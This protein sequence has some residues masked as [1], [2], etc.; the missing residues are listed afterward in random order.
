MLEKF[1]DILGYSD[2]VVYNKSNKNTT[3]LFIK[4]LIIA[5][6]LTI[7]INK[8]LIFKVNVPTASMVPTLNVNDIL[9]V[10]RVPNL[11]TLKFGDIVVFYSDEFDGYMVKRLIGLPGDSITMNKGILYVNGEYKTESYI[12]YEDDYT[13][14]FQVPEEKYFFLGDNRIVSLDS[15]LWNKT[16]IDEED[17]MGVVKFKIYPF[18]DIGSIK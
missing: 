17:I 7:L 11:N 14:S 9:L 12:Q 13:G 18:K 6:V 15:R 8:F 1:Q 16:F 2:K 3:I 10:G 4:I 5:I